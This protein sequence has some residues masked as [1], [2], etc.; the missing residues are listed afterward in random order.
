MPRI[1]VAMDV[2]AR[3]LFGTFVAT[4]VKAM[5]DVAVFVASQR[6]GM[7]DAEYNKYEQQHST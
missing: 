5:A 7:H 3:P 1:V 4:M 6:L 2:I